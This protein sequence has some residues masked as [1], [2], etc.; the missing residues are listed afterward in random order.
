MDEAGVEALGAE[1]AGRIEAPAIVALHG[2]M[3]AGKSVLARAIARGLGVEGPM[4]SPTWSL[5]LSYPAREVTVVHLD[6]FRLEDPDAIWE[7]GW[8]DLGA[9]NEVVLVEWAERA[10][11][12]LPALR[13]DIRIERVTGDPGLREV[14]V[15]PPGSAP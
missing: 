10:G 14:R 5:L 4:P 11:A 12:H 15:V 7:L 13:W 9:S 3:G 8:Q 6:L 1:L 2:P